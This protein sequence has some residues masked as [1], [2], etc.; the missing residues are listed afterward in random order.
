[1]RY[2]ALGAQSSSKVMVV[3]F[4]E[5]F[6]VCSPTFLASAPLFCRYTETVASTPDLST[7]VTV[8]MP[9]SPSHLA[10]AENSLML[11]ARALLEAPSTIAVEAA[12]TPR[13]RAAR[14]VRRDMG[15]NATFILHGVRKCGGWKGW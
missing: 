13:K 4:L 7:S 10:S 9:F 6:T 3:P 2:S 12:A 1:M 8:M 5:P 14:E 15:V 11:Q